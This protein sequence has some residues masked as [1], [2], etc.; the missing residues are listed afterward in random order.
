MYTYSS[1]Q[2]QALIGWLKDYAWEYFVTLHPG[3]KMNKSALS[4]VLAQ[5]IARINHKNYGK[6]STRQLNWFPVLEESPDG[7]LHIHLVMGGPLLKL[8][9]DTLKQEI[10]SAWINTKG[11]GKIPYE[12]LFNEEWFKPVW[13]LEGAVEYITKKWRFDPDL[14][15]WDNVNR[16]HR[17]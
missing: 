13:G 7:W 8:D 12:K 1:E 16:F 14:V 11:A 15:D 17:Q 3:T 6:R 10:R 5:L 9:K 2:Q 4:K